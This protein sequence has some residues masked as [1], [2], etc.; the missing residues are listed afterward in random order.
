MKI[1]SIL[2]ITN[3]QLKNSPSISFITQSHTNIKRINYGDL[4]ISSNQQDISV[5]I[6]NG[7]FAIIYDC[8]L[9]IDNLDDEIAY[10]KVDDIQDAMI[11]L[12]RFKLSS[13]TIDTLY[14]DKISYK[15]LKIYNTNKD[16][17]YLEFDIV[18]IFELL[19]DNDIKKIISPNKELLDLIYPQHKTFK[20]NRYD[21]KNLITHS[22]FQ[23]SFSLQNRYFYKIKLPLIYIDN[24]I[25][26]ISFLD[27]RDIDIHKLK[28]FDYMKPIFIDRL[29][30]IVRFGESNR[31]ILTNTDDTLSKLEIKFINLFYSFSKIKQIDYSS[32]TTLLKL[33]SKEDY[34]ILY[35]NNISYEEMVN[36]LQKNI[37]NNSN[38]LF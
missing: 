23:T 29:K 4:F 22:A 6:K 31:F 33:L 12:L 10:I 25:S 37:N 11:R 28:E 34:N 2:D 17:I 18:N 27:I 32:D 9:D 30:H 36:F 20:I 19:Q 8:Y 1:S 24:F 26:V 3:G 16:I 21:L 35:I 38:Q 15:L 7:A 13:Q 5:A 14:M